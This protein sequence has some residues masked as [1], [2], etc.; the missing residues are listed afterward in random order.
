M[1]AVLP[2]SI[3]RYFRPDAY[4]RGR[5]VV[6]SCA[7]THK[8]TESS[9]IFCERCWGLLPY[10]MRERLCTLWSPDRDRS[11]QSEAFNAVLDAAAAKGAELLAIERKYS[12]PPGANG[13]T[14]G[15]TNGSK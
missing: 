14:N 10:A 5:C 11:K 4:R 9:R 1:R 15:P 6:S 13:S 7:E 12:A 8:P 2:E 3:A